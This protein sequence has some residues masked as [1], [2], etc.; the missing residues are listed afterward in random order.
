MKALWLPYLRA[1]GMVVMM[2]VVMMMVVIAAAAERV[3]FQA[4]AHLRAG[5]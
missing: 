2:M 5:P 4:P 3:L 1:L